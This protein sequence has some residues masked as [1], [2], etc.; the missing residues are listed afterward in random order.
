VERGR[1]N[2]K[3][4]S[5]HDHPANLE[6]AIKIVQV[7]HNQDWAAYGHRVIRLRDGWMEKWDVRMEAPEC[8]T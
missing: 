7:T 1:N 2:P 4:I 8:P 5:A 3:P 6:K